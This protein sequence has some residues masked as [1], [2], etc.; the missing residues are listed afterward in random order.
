LSSCTNYDDQFDD[1]NSQLTTLKSQIEGFSSLSSGLT[2]L[3]GTV[4]ALSAA[5]NA[6]PKTAT[7]ATDI[8]G[9]QAG[10]TALAATVAELKTSLATAATTADVAA[11]TASL[12]KVQTDLA[13]LLAS[14]NI[15]TPASPGLVVATQA[16]LTF[17]TAL[18]D[19]VKIINGSVNV[20][21]TASMN[22]T[23]L[24]TLMAKITS[25][26]E[27]A[28][29][30]ANATG[31]TPV[32]GFTSL[33]GAGN[34]TLDVS[35]PIS[36][37]VLATAAVVNVTNNAMTTSFSAP[38]LTSVTSFTGDALALSKATSIDLSSLEKYDGALLTITQ[39]SGLVNLDA[40]G[41]GPATGA[42]LE[43]TNSVTL[44]GATSLALSSKTAG[45]II[46]NDVTAA[47][48]LPVWKGKAGASPVSS[49]DKA[50]E[51]VLPAITGGVVIN[52]NNMAPKATKFHYIGTGLAASSTVTNYPTF[53]T[54]AS[55]T[56]LETLII[57]GTST[58]VNI[59]DATD[60]T[61]L[62]FTGAANTVTLNDLESMTAI[63]LGYVS[64]IGS[65][66]SGTLEVSSNE[67]LESLTADS[68]DDISSLD[69]SANGNLA[70]ISFAALNSL[71]TSNAGVALT[72][73]NINITG[74]NFTATNIQLPS[75]ATDA[76]A[77][78][79]AITT[80]SGLNQLEVYAGLAAAKS[81]TE[82][83]VIDKVEKV[84]MKDGTTP[85]SVPAITSAT[86]ASKGFAWAGADLS[87]TLMSGGTAASG[88]T[89][90]GRLQTATTGLNEAKFTNANSNTT[91]LAGTEVITLQPNTLGTALATVT[92]N[93]A[94]TNAISG[95]NAG[96]PST[97]ASAI[98]TEMNRQLDAGGHAYD[99]SIANDFGENYTY[100]VAATNAVSG[101]ATT[102]VTGSYKFKFN[103]V[104]LTAVV[105]IAGNDGVE[106]AIIAAINTGVL[107]KIF[108]A[109]TGSLDGPQ[110][111]PLT[112]QGANDNAFANSS[113]EPALTWI[114]YTNN[115]SNTQDLQVSQTINTTASKLNKGWRITVKNESLTV[116]ADQLEPGVNFAAFGGTLTSTTI[117]NIATAVVGTGLSNTGVLVAWTDRKASDNGT[118]DAGTAS[119]NLTSW[120]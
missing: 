59:S 57:D 21:Q 80:T 10:L 116:K 111:F 40:L 82:L 118:Y 33:L 8:S 38:K 85:S 97:Y 66:S 44:V 54:G 67:K 96:D 95:Y 12:T 20:T 30:T 42:T 72:A 13:E 34:V 26:T 63:T 102:I 32:A 1:L 23:E 65:Y 73:A 106:D 48:S 103:N 99:V 18:G 110:V 93:S 36:L 86:S 71:G 94:F 46:A 74:N 105:T 6:L 70:K 17:A 35:G 31:I 55:N 69:I 64:K 27:E 28:R 90:G 100:Q 68:L 53:T 88:A 78:T 61:S 51:V 112:N 45:D 19:K 50:S 98:A 114:G 83:L 84:T 11:L 5:V 92:M 108:R 52:L 62:T 14:N 60:L 89:F 87:V 3:T 107:S 47:I 22:A 16:Q 117:S 76:V 109:Q 104:A 120:F 39:K 49:F 25:V 37:P 2:S 115:T 29:F 9:L 24:A 41:N 4:S 119:V 81:T 77:V 7:P 79:A 101:N 43:T 75:D 91:P 113:S 15:Y 58:S 56:N